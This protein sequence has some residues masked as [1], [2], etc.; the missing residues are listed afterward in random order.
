MT[1]SLM[2]KPSVVYE[3]PNA[4]KNSVAFQGTIADAEAAR[5]VTTRGRSEKRNMLAGPLTNVAGRLKCVP[6]SAFMSEPSEPVP[7]RVSEICP[8]ASFH[9]AIECSSV[10]TTKP[11]L[12]SSGS[13]VRVR[14]RLIRILVS[15]R[16]LSDTVC[17][18]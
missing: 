15:D 5:E 4:N 14:K 12:A 17:S 8:R 2:L 6:L 16:I 7:Q 10:P 13:C 3:S 18:G 9:A 11:P 1:P